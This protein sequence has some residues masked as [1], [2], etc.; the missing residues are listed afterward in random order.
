MADTRRLVMLK[1]VEAVL[2]GVSK[3][4][5]LNVHRFGFRAIE[6]DSLPALVVMD[7]GTAEFNEEVNE[8]REC[9]DL[10]NVHIL[11]LGNQT[12]EPDDL[13]DPYL[14]WVTEA[15]MADTTLGGVVSHLVMQARGATAMEERDRIYI[16]IVQPVR[17]TYYHRHDDLEAAS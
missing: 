17:V 15:L 6:K 11:A 14:S 8:L 4:T 10:V 5:G 3:P 1:A 13:I 16:G 7:G 9:F 12:T 2:D